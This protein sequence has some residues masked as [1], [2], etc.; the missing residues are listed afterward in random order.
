MGGVKLKLKLKLPGLQAR[1]D[2]RSAPCQYL[3]VCSRG[4]PCSNSSQ[5]A[6]R[7]CF[8]AGAACPQQPAHLLHRVP[9]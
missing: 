6:P 7:M 1:A 3:R 2:G 5:Q 9:K 8:N 4:G